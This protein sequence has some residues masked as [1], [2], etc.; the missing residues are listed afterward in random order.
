MWAPLSRGCFEI[1]EAQVPN[2]KFRR[3]KRSKR[4]WNESNMAVCQN[5]VP[6][7]N[8]KIAGKWM[9]IPLKMVLIGI[10][11]LT[12]VLI[13]PE[14][15]PFNWLCRIISPSRANTWIKLMNYKV[16]WNSPRTYW[17]GYSCIMLYSSYWYHYRT[18][19]H[20]IIHPCGD[21]TCQWTIHHLNLVPYLYHYKRMALFSAGIPQQAMQAMLDDT[22]GYIRMISYKVVLF[23]L[24]ILF[25]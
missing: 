7:V 9:L 6:L 15:N 2:E 16:D 5:L 20:Y 21:Q 12:V 3:K 14:S 25:S 4:R 18:W 24:R 17:G 10:D 19:Y 8:I 1:F 11:S 23:H 22:G 13:W